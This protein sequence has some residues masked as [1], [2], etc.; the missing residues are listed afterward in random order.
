MNKSNGTIS[1]ASCELNDGIAIFGL[2]IISIFGIITN[3]LTSMVFIKIIMKRRLTKIAPMYYFLTGKSI[4]ELIMFWLQIL[5]P[6]YFADRT[7]KSIIP[8]IWYIYGFNYLT[9]VLL[10]CSALLEIAASIDIRFSSSKSS[11]QAKPIV[12]ILF[13]ILFLTF[14]SI[15]SLVNLFRY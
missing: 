1:E 7:S 9:D 14:A 12:V 8:Q 2:P 3:S 4:M 5:S 15:F 13:I 11:K 6:I 10:V